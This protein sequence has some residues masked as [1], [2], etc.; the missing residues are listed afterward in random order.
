MIMSKERKINRLIGIIK[1][2]LRDIEMAYLIKETIIGEESD[3]DKEIKSIL[4]W[5]YEGDEVVE[6]KM[7]TKKEEIERYLKN[8]SNLNCL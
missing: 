1:G 3:N 6:Y 5:R 4:I 7:I 2:E 8:D